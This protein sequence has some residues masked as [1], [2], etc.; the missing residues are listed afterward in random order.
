MCVL[1]MKRWR[2]KRGRVHLQRHV[3][4]ISKAGIYWGSRG[5]VI[6]PHP[7]PG[8]AIDQLFINR[9]Y[10]NARANSRYNTTV[11]QPNAFAPGTP[12]SCA[13]SEKM[14]PSAEDTRFAVSTAFCTDASWNPRANQFS[15][16]N[17]SSDEPNKCA[18]STPGG[19]SST[20]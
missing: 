13:M 7:Q 14:V 3:M 9:R 15:N 12:P 16:P 11:D 2:R 1:S 4:I 8:C 10:A 18:T 17:P 5:E 19:L 6:S 20:L